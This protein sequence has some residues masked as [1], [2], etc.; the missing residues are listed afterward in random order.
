MASAPS[1]LDVAGLISQIEHTTSHVPQSEELRQSLYD[2]TRKLNL[3]LESSENT[4]QRMV[5][6]ASVPISC[7]TSHLVCALLISIPMSQASQPATARIAHQLGLF[8]LLVKCGDRGTT[9]KEILKQTEA[10][11]ILLRTCTAIYSLRSLAERLT[12]STGRVMRY[13]ASMGMVNE[14]SLDTYAPSNITRTLSRPDVIGSLN[15]S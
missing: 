1:D 5:H 14:I 12:F 2:A 9:I 3:A 15:F 8:K 7:I 13:L 6:W 10:D 4:L 11:E